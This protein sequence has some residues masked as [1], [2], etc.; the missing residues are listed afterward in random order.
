MNAF[1][2]LMTKPQLKGP[3]RHHYISRFYLEGFTDSEGLLQVFDRTNGAMRR[4]QPQDTTV[5]G[6]LYTFFDAQ[7]R[8]RFE[9]E[10]LFSMVESRAGLALK[11][12][13][14]GERLSHEERSYL[15]LFIA[16]TAIRTPAALE[17][18]RLV[19]EKIH[20][21]EMKLRVSNE[22]QAYSIVSEILPPDTK[23]EKL[24]DFAAAVYEMV[25]KDQ[26]IVTVPDEL[27]RQMS[28][29]Q[30]ASVA[31]MLN[32]RDWTV[33]DAP[34]GHEYMSSDSPVVLTSLPGMDKHPLGFG[35]LHTRVLFPLSRKVALVMDGNGGRFRRTTGRPEQVR[36]FNLTVA[37]DCYRFVIATKE[38]SMRQVVVELGLAETQWQA[39]MDVGVGSHPMSGDQA[40]WIRRRGKELVAKGI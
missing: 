11:A 38:D 22:Q 14:G 15:S 17:E 30:W 2:R 19:R 13:I 31:E 3:K 21:V 26:F 9:L 16:M 37:A 28:L 39:R 29:K 5:I 12:L 36:R 7:D 8:R 10:S 40:I 4:Q 27:A 18:A 23:E 20:R 34:D 33:V 1:D 24:R 35:S 25:S 32:H 6:Y